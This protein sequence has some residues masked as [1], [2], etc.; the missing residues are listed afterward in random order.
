MVC[1]YQNS[2][3]LRT[4]EYSVRQLFEGESWSEE[5]DPVDDSHVTVFRNAGGDVVDS[6]GEFCGEYSTLGE[7]R[8][9]K[10]RLQRVW[11]I[12]QA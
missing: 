8:V 5:I 12:M 10:D 4:Y 6:T 2:T 1:K 3:G 11:E 7:A 9:A